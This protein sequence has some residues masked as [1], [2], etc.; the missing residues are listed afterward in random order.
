MHDKRIGAG[1]YAFWLSLAGLMV[2]AGIHLLAA[3]GSVLVVDWLGLDRRL[4]LP[5]F[6]LF[7]VFWWG[8]ARVRR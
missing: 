4:A 6:V 1:E 3:W 2:V 8:R 5:L 7:C